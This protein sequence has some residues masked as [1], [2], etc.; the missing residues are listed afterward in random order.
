MEIQKNDINI[1]SQELNKGILIAN[2]LKVKLGSQQKTNTLWIVT[3]IKEKLKTP[4]Q[5]FKN[6][7]FSFRRTHEAAVKNSKILAASKGDLGTAILA[8]KDSP[9]KYVLEF[10][11]IA[12]LENLFFYHEYGTKIINII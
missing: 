5:K 1:Q 4:I 3:T 12:P 10:S 2:T 8:Q 6:P 9:V 7:I 11:D